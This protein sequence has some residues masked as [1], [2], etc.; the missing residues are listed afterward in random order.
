MGLVESSPILFTDIV[1]AENLV[2]E[3]LGEVSE[4]DYFGRSARVLDGFQ[5]SD[6][7]GNEQFDAASIMPLDESFRV[8]LL[9]TL[10]KLMFRLRKLKIILSF[11]NNYTT[12]Q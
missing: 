11:A 12:L 1:K 8:S 3:I 9:N 5:I 6:P 10:L 2:S 7:T 4:D